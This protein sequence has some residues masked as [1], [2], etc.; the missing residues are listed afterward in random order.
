MSH[1]TIWDIATTE[2][3]GTPF[4]EMVGMMVVVSHDPAIFSTRL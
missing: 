3:A 4:V 2:M 1:Q